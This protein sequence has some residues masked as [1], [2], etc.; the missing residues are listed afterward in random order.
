MPLDFFLSLCDKMD[1]KAGSISP[2][3]VQRQ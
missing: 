3:N 2:V 1:Q